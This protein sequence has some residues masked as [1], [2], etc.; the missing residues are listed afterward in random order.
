M[1]DASA[2]RS[3]PLLLTD[4]WSTPHATARPRYRSSLLR[5]P[6]LRRVRVVDRPQQRPRR[7]AGEMRHDILQLAQ[8]LLVEMAEDRL[9]LRRRRAEAPGLTGGEPRSDEDGHD[10]A[11]RHRI[12]DD[13]VALAVR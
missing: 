4:R 10:V 9:G 13:F 2:P 12:G 7:D 6:L 5:L 3:Q 11:A 1:L 8:A